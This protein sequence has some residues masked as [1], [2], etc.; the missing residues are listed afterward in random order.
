LKITK[1]ELC[2]SAI[3]LFQENGFEKVSI[4]DICAKGCVTKGSFYH[5]FSCKEELLL[6]WFSEHAEK[7]SLAIHENENDSPYKRLINYLEIYATGLSELGHN[8]LYYTAIAD[9]SMKQGM[10]IMGTSLKDKFLYLFDMTVS[11]VLSA[12]ADGDIK[13]DTSAEMLIEIFSWSIIGL[14]FKWKQSDGEL[15]FSQNVREIINTIF[16]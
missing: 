6:F 16:C 11:L 8:L 15:D 5:H 2:Q 3:S 13:S 7:M 9:S 14:I 4:N 12:Q 1:E 10:F